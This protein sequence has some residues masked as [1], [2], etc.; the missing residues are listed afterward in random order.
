LTFGI[1]NIKRTGG[2]ETDS[3]HHRFVTYQFVLQAKIQYRVNTVFTSVTATGTDAAGHPQVW[4]ND[5]VSRMNR[6][7]FRTDYAKTTITARLGSI[8][9]F[10]GYLA[11]EPPIPFGDYDVGGIRMHTVPDCRA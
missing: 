7:V 10:D 1:V 5:S 4:H 9:H 11:F 3:G 8:L 6:D 2:G